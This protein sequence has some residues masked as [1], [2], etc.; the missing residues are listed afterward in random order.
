MLIIMGVGNHDERVTRLWSENHLVMSLYMPFIK[1]LGS[2][3]WRKAVKS[4]MT[5]SRPNWGNRGMKRGQGHTEKL[6][7]GGLCSN[8]GAQ[9]PAQ[10][11]R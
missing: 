7:L 9:P 1:F 4:V 3:T 10:K 8:G 11:L 6:G 2:G 5:V